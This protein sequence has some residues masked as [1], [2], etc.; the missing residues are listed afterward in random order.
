MIDSWGSDLDSALSLQ[1]IQ[2]KAICQNN[3]PIFWKP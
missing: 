1:T 3:F 2:D